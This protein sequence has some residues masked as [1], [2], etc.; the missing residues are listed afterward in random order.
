MKSVYLCLYLVIISTHISGQTRFSVASGIGSIP[1]PGFNIHHNL[2]LSLVTDVKD[3]FTLSFGAQFMSSK[4]IH[5]RKDFISCDSFEPYGW[6][7]QC[8]DGYDS[9]VNSAYYYQYQKSEISIHGL[10]HH[11]T[12]NRSLTGIGV[13][14]VFFSRQMFIDDELF[15]DRRPERGT[16]VAITG[17]QIYQLPIF[18]PTSGI[19]LVLNLQGGVLYS[20]QF[21]CEDAS[22]DNFFESSL[23]VTG[24]A[25]LGLT[26]ALN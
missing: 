12:S 14:G 19:Q 25:M 23:Q 1:E 9:V 22:C 4:K 24:G 26:I 6:G 5:D 17:M 20:P 13:S 21:I 2:R 18:K 3:Q 11:G 10:W 7:W 8:V 15:D 16:G